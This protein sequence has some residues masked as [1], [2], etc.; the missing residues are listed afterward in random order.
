MSQAEKVRISL[1]LETFSVSIKALIRSRKG[2]TR[3][4]QRVQRLKQEI[5][6]KR[7]SILYPNYP[8]QHSTQAMSSMVPNLMTPINK[9]SFRTTIST[10]KPVDLHMNLFFPVVLVLQIKVT[11]PRCTPKVFLQLNFSSKFL[12][13]RNMAT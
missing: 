5:C 9:R 4:N 10:I 13:F 12:Q 11:I 2:I 6:V 3:I 8:H 1:T 7:Q